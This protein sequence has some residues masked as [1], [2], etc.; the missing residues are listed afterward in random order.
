MRALSTVLVATGLCLSQPVYAA[1]IIAPH[2]AAQTQQDTDYQAMLRCYGFHFFK[3]ELGTTIGNAEIADAGRNQSQ[4]DLAALRKYAA[5]KGVAWTIVES[6]A[7]A[8]AKARHTLYTD[9]NNPKRQE[10]ILEDQTFCTS[11]AFVEVLLR[12]Q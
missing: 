6:A 7:N 4:L 11:N 8:E 12:Y 9:R 10:T 1:A 2:T 3:I 5:G